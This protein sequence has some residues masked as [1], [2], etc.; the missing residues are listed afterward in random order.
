MQIN[1]LQILLVSGNAKLNLRFAMRVTML[2]S[3]Y[4]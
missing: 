3:I 4:S 2:E 1:D